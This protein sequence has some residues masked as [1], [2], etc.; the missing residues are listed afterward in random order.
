MLTEIS[1]GKFNIS[2]HRTY[3]K[4]LSGVT[5]IPESSFTGRSNILFAADVDVEV[6]GDNFLPAYTQGDNSM[7][8]ATDSMKNFVLSESAKFE[9]STLEALLEFLARRFL[10]TYAQI[11]GI[12]LSARELPFVAMRVPG[13]SADGSGGFEDSD[14]LYAPT[15]DDCGLAMIELERAGGGVRV[16]DHQCGR[17]GMH[18]LK[19]TGSSFAAFVRDDYTTL[20]ELQDRPLF[21]HTNILWRYGNINDLLS[22]DPAKYVAPEQIA[23]IAR[24]VFHGFNSKSIQELVYRIGERILE[25]FP[26]VKE[27]E[28]E[29]QNRTW[30]KAAQSDHDEKI[31]VY[32]QPRAP[33]GNITLKMTRD[34]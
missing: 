10:E 17:I 12:R 24:V 29:S 32:W 13:G 5:A 15:H 1:Y 7:V 16:A 8:V 34:V 9:G 25:R 20:P 23:D 14:V 4:P 31:K 2:F 22:G 28:F 18:L 19:I 11:P 33:Y 30:D 3:A 27:L 6:F 26:Q 21:I